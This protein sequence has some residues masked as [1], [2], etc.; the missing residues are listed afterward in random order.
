MMAIHIAT[1]DSPL[2]WFCEMVLWEAN[3]LADGTFFLNLSAKGLASHNE[4]IFSRGR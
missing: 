2:K 4:W 1:H 3:P